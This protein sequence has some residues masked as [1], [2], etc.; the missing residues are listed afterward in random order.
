V[1]QT[2]TS[3][4]SPSARGESTQ[5]GLAIGI[6]LGLLVGPMLGNTGLGIALGA[7]LGLLFGAAIDT[8]RRRA[9]NQDSGKGAS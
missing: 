4:G 7:A 8:R 3:G 6:S 5:A 2:T 9:A 1:T